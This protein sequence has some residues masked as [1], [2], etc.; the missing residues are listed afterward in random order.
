MHR[1]QVQT[2]STIS[3]FNIR[4][5]NKSSGPGTQ[6]CKQSRMAWA[7]MRLYSGDMSSTRIFSSCDRSM[8]SLS[9]A[10]KRYQ[11]YLSSLDFPCELW[12]VVVGRSAPEQFTCPGDWVFHTNCI[13]V[14]RTYLVM[15][16]SEAYHI[17]YIY[18]PWH[19]ASSFLL[20]RHEIATGAREVS[21][22][23]L[24]GSEHPSWVHKYLD[25]AEA[26]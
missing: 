24:I 22:P 11:L 14:K 7:S 20:P 26:L 21:F 5:E 1:D 15:R 9:K 6:K 10:G 4:T 13:Y 16:S 18:L 8:L 2:S 3:I 25:L 23:P 17:Y 12:N 19:P